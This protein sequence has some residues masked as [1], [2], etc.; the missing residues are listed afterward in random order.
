MP[1]AASAYTQ[2]CAQH[3]AIPLMHCNASLCSTN[4]LS[5][6]RVESKRGTHAGSAAATALQCPHKHY[7]RLLMLQIS[8]SNGSVAVYS[9]ALLLL[10]LLLLL[11]LQGWR[12][13]WRGNGTNVI[14]IIPESAI[15]FMGYDFFKRAICKDPDVVRTLKYI[16]YTC[17][18][19]CKIWSL[20]TSCLESSIISTS[21]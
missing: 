21:A 9:Y 1:A 14:K 15:R 6:S 10:L 11:I 19:A 5:M 13:F 2:L 16:Y 3:Y 7:F 18:S 8:N 12:G 4:T 20:Y 17:I